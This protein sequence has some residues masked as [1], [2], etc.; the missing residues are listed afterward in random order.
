MLDGLGGQY[1]QNSNGLHF[2]TTAGSASAGPSRSAA[3]GDLFADSRVAH[4]L[5]GPACGRS[6]QKLE[7]GCRESLQHVGL[8]AEHHGT[9]PFSVS[10]LHRWALSVSK[11]G[12]AS[13]LQKV[14][15]DIFC[16]LSVQVVCS[17]TNMCYILDPADSCRIIDG[18]EVLPPCSRCSK[19]ILPAKSGAVSQQRSRDSSDHVGASRDMQHARRAYGRERRDSR[20]LADRR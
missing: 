2:A 3:P 16:S 7:R 14:P 4:D 8:Q 5:R 12:A 15:T 17:K 6:K 20:G 10:T 13:C 19:T 9:L 18:F 1:S 11:P